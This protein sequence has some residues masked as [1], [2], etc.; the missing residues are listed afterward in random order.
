MYGAE[1]DELYPSR[2]QP[3]IRFIPF[4]EKGHISFYPCCFNSICK[5]AVRPIFKAQVRSHSNV[6]RREIVPI[7]FYVWNMIPVCQNK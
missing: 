6:P 5:Q 7:L 4:S 3:H 2:H 1:M